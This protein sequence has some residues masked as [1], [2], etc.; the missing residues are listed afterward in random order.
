MADREQKSLLRSLLRILTPEEIDD[1]SKIYLSLFRKSLTGLID[2]KINL[3]KM[4]NG[5]EAGPTP[6]PISKI[7]R[8][9]K[10]IRDLPPLLDS[11]PIGGVIFYLDEK[12]KF[13]DIYKKQ[14]KLRST[15]E[16]NVRVSG[17]ESKGI[18]VNKKCA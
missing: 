10:K 15:Y 1:L 12:E 4:E 5:Y 9:R 14:K 8:V 17:K 6:P 16:K 7:K 18:L 13:K 11:K 3:E 2:E